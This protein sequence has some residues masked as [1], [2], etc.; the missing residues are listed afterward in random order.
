[1]SL[2]YTGIPY[3]P[4]TSNFFEEDV[5][6]L[7]EAKYGIRASYL[8]IR[9][10][11]K[12]YKEGYYTTW[13]KEQCII[14]LRKAGGE[15]NE[16]GMNQIMDLLLEKGF[17]DKES[18]EKYSILT[19]ESIQKVWMEAT[20]RRKR[21]LSKMPYLLKSVTESKPKKS[22][23]KEEVNP[24]NADNLPVQGELN[25]END[26]NSGQSKGKQT[27][28]EKTKASS[29]E[30]EEGE[31]GGKSETPFVIPG[32]A[33]NTMTHNI[34]GL[35]ECLER[36][37][38]SDPKDIQ[39]ILRLSDYGKKGTSIWRLF[40]STNWNK[41]EAPGRYI[42]AALTAGERKGLSV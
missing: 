1:M 15:V 17:F 39:S 34:N 6:E 20:F 2:E 40:S 18:Y 36:Y 11:S 4:L 42:I 7:L 35:I 26:S 37:K 38:V 19:S 25:L 8:L 10:L 5:P 29:S 3:F 12:I 22:K 24:E 41:I 30:K 28:Q 33:Y 23:Q 13:G 9:L 31:G 27:K 21:D 14:F 16:E 32:Y